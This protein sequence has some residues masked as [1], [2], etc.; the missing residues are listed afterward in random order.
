MAG[1]IAL[2]GLR[3]EYRDPG[4]RRFHAQPNA[5]PVCGPRVDFARCPMAVR[6]PQPQDV[7]VIA[8]ALARLQ[9]LGEILAIKGLGG[10]HLVCDAQN[11]AA[12]ARLRQ[13]KQRDAKPFAV[14]AANGASLA[15]LGRSRSRRRTGDCWNRRN[16]P[17]LLLRQPLAEPGE[18]ARGEGERASAARHRARSGASGRDAALHAAALPAVPRSGRATGRHGVAGAC[19][20][21][22]CW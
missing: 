16:G 20:N 2:P 17:S 18:E 1:F 8:A 21:R 4:D 5:C 13:R 10:F 22:C 11:P 6:R 19:R 12:V 9:T 14:M 7:D 3:A 15:R